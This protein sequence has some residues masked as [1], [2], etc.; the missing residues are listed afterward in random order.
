MIG[1]A[2]YGRGNRLLEHL[3]PSSA[4]AVLAGSEH[5][6]MND[7]A[8]IVDPERLIEYVVF[9]FTCVLSTLS[10]L[11]DRTAVETAVTGCEGMAPMAL[12]HGVD[13]VSEHVVV[14]VPGEGLRVP[15]AVFN[16]AVATDSGFQR[17]LHRYAV[18]LFTFAAQASGCN[19][20]HSVIQRCARWL[21]QTHDRVPGDEFQLTHLF[22]SQMMGV[23]RSS[24]TVAAEAL[25]AAGAISYTRGAVRIVNRATLESQAC[26]CYAIV[27]SVFDRLLTSGESASPLEGLRMSANG[28]SLAGAPGDA[29]QA[30]VMESTTVALTHRTTG[31]PKAR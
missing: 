1:K 11:P 17:M 30:S 7:G 28:R 13:R 22:L 3:A 10:V 5:V 27:R 8:A 19:R 12:F 9:P 25:R 23:R 24:V 4:A 16:T 29:D 14:Q 21:L 18:A 2:N 15:A 31:L 6:Y 26:A 20:Q